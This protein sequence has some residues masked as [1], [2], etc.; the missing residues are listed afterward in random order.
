[1]KNKIISVILSITIVLSAILQPVVVR[2][3]P[4][5]YVGGGLFALLMTALAHAGYTVENQDSANYIYNFFFKKWLSDEDLEEIKE[6]DLESQ[7]N[8]KKFW[9]GIAEKL[10]T[11]LDSKYPS[12][13]GVFEY[14]VT[15][16]GAKIVANCTPALKQAIDQLVED[17]PT[18]TIENIGSL[19]S[20]PVQSLPFT[21]KNCYFPSVSKA[22]SFSSPFLTSD[23]IKIKVKPV[24]D[25]SNSIVY[26][27][28]DTAFNEDK[29]AT[30]LGKIL[31]ANVPAGVT[32]FSF[33]LQNRAYEWDDITFSFYY[34]S[35][36]TTYDYN[37]ANILR[38]D[39]PSYDRKYSFTID[40]VENCTIESLE[41]CDSLWEIPFNEGS[42][43]LYRDNEAIWEQMGSIEAK[44]DDVI[45]QPLTDSYPQ[46]IGMTFPLTQEVADTYVQEKD[47]IDIKSKDEVKEEE[48]NVPVVPEIPI[49][50]IT[51]NS[52]KLTD[53]FPFCIPFD[54]VRSVQSFKDTSNTKIEFDV[55]IPYSNDPLHFCLDFQ[56]FEVVVII[57]RF[58][59]LLI[60]II[61]M[62]TLTRNIIRG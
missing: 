13:K 58:F 24:D 6:L 57:F 51:D 23:F 44:L 47:E 45:S 17:L 11:P 59:S 32:E 9:K 42:K 21:L 41:I 15:S 20:V 18:S 26:F 22:E 37:I 62:L 43:A 7:A 5:V 4:V 12:L 36:K 38:P 49:D 55:P 10:T 35:T 30:G 40:S 61:S 29:Y 56:K 16:A 52:S 25:S 46:S 8:A 2:A 60:F 14:K 31:S 28:F 1:M 39:N 19:S 50:G 27:K 48:S 3:N 33:Y 53:K 34:D 54:L